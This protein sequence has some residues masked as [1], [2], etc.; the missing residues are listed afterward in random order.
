M[1]LWSFGITF[2]PPVLIWKPL[3]YLENGEIAVNLVRFLG[4]GV[5]EAYGFQSFAFYS[6]DMYNNLFVLYS[7]L[8]GEV[9]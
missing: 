6:L 8:Y 4:L 7:I 9:M 5:I 3:Q 1:G 2:G